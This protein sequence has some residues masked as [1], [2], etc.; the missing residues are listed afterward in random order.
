MSQ[1]ETLIKR[2]RRIA[3]VIERPSPSLVEDAKRWW[4]ENERFN[5]QEDAIRALFDRHYP[6]HTDVVGVLTKVTVLD[7]FYSTNLYSKL[8]VAKR[9]IELNTAQRL[10][11]ADFSLVNEMATV[12]VQGKSFYFYSFA[13]KYCSQHSPDTFPIYDELVGLTLLNLN[14][15]DGFGDFTKR[16]LKDYPQY[17]RVIH[18]FRS[19]YGLEQFS[20]RWIDRYLWLTG[21]RAFPLKPKE[22]K[23]AT[24]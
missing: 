2:R 23:K 20:L 22:E 9:I 3:P 4:G 19:F 8:P 12:S 13:S 6:N 7:S 21:R 1:D 16:D 5:I 10:A 15:V 17:V 24:V 11:E 14:A 18:A